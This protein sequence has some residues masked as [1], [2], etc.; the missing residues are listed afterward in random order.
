M[1]TD[2][3]LPSIIGDRDTSEKK[4][5]QLSCSESSAG[6]LNHCDS[7]LEGYQYSCKYV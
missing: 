1:R 2:L 5:Y 4:N 6:N 3:E 7:V